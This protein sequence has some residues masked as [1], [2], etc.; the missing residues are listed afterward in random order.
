MPKLRT[1]LRALTKQA[2]STSVIVATLAVAIGAV[3]VVVSTIDLVWRLVPI[4]DRARFVLVA[5]S[6]TRQI[7][8][9]AGTVARTG[10][11]IPDLADWSAE[12]TSFEAFTALAIGTATLSGIDVPVGVSVARVTTNLLPLWGITATLGRTF[13]PDES[14]PRQDNAVMLTHRFWERQFSASGAVLGQNVRVNGQARSIVGVLPASFSTGVLRNVDI[15]LPLDVDPLRATRDDRSLFVLGR[16]KPGVTRRAAAAELSVIAT[17]LQAEHPTTNARIG[18]IVDPLVE[19]SG[20]SVRLLLSILGL[21]AALLFV[22]ACANVANILLARNAARQHESAVRAALGGTRLDRVR[23]LMVEH[24]LMAVAGGA[25]G[26]VFA[27][28]CVNMLRS[29]AGDVPGFADIAV[30]T[31]VLLTTILVS[32]VAPLV[33]GLLPAWRATSVG[34]DSLR[35]GVRSVGGRRHTLTQRL[36]TGFQVALS[37]ILTVQVTLLSLSAWRLSTIDTGFEPD[38]LLTFRQELPERWAAEPGRAA[39]F[40]TQVLNAVKSIPG[41]ENAATIDRL[42][43]TE[44]EITGPLFIDGKAD[45]PPEAQPISARAA[46]SS[47]YLTTMR[48]PVLRGR[49]FSDAEVEGNDRVAVVS[50]EAVRRYFEGRDPIGTRIA[51][52]PATSS[53]DWLTVVGVVGDVRNSDVDQGAMPT[54]CTPSMAQPDQSIA[55]VVRSAGSD[56]ISLVSAIRSVVAG[57]DS[58]QAV[59][60][61]A[62]MRQVLA[63]D[64]SGTMVLTAILV[65]VGLVAVCLAASGI[66]GVAS[67]AVGQRTR[68]IGLRIALGAAPRAAVRL[69]L[70]QSAVPVLAGGAI[71]LL[72]ALPLASQFAGSTTDSTF[73]EPLPYAAIVIF[74]LAVAAVASYIPARRAARVDPMTALR[75][76]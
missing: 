60:D 56:P 65:F 61:A 3:T 29:L 45:L 1:A 19:A 38:G 10:V 58:D 16:L 28:A 32:L 47:S 41:V 63:D 4:A 33:F 48:I 62:S 53:D 15:L 76:E 36:L 55:F 24:T 30:S 20:T 37:V 27:I 6:D 75:M 13:L 22:M 40:V 18:A 39:R 21:I 67:F 26:V 8:A 44:R 54:V 71:G 66:Y 12:S 43:V 72:V 31:R 14:A 17:R 64:V 73:R 68:E 5:S 35:D 59:L 70:S 46:I 11:S 52:G 69:I 25:L 49:S 34:L 7:G 74:L 2:G 57:I 9:A 50:A 23:E 51:L 42:P